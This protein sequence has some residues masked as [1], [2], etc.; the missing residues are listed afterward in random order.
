MVFGSFI[1]PMSPLVLPPDDHEPRQHLLSPLLRVQGVLAG[2]E[3]VV[4]AEDR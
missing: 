2:L 4:I 1:R 3:V